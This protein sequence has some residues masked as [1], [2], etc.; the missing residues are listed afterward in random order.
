MFRILLA[1]DEGIMLE[2]LRTIIESNFKG[3]VEIQ[4]VKSGRAAIELAETFRP[5][6]VFMDIQ[7]PGINGIHAMQEIRK[8]HTSV[9]FIVI[10][11]YDKFAYAQEAINLG[12]LEYLTKPVNRKVVIDV[13]VRA[14]QKVEE[15]RRKRSES[16]K[17]QEKLETVI[18]V[19]E[20]GFIYNL[21]LQEERNRETGNYRQLLDIREEYGF[22]MVVQFG[23]A[24]TE[25]VLTNA[26]GMSVKAQS[27]YSQFREIIRGFFYCCI[28]PVMSNK[29]A[30]FVPWE[31]GELTYDERIQIIEKSRNMVRRLEKDID[32]KFKVGIG[33]VK[34]FEELQDSYKEASRALTESKGRVAHVEDLPI[35]CGYVGDYPADTEKKLFQMVLRGDTD[36]ARQQA[37]L[38]FEWMLQNYPDCQADIQIKVLEFV[39]RAEREAFLNGGMTYEFRY[40]KDYLEQVTGCSS[41]EGLRTWFLQKITEVCKNITSKQEEQTEGIVT[42]VKQY[43]K[44]NFQ[45]DISLDGVSEM[46]NISPYYFSKVFKDEAGENFIEYLTKVRMENAKE[47]LKN[48]ELSVKEIC[49]MSGYGDP[50]YFSRIFKK[51]IGVTP[52]EYRERLG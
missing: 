27:F 29:I 43:I 16:L 38:F 31:Q 37:D 19:I 30:L 41:Y 40:R 6:I 28:G 1:D 8:F 51:Y 45:K 13:L 9:H 22:M 33:G 18:P 48:P 25:G 44:S 50:N 26:V 35:G 21:L 15:E 2:S 34:P 3:T 52:S 36:G 11:A 10:S 39:M 5:D 7:M 4:C 20:S 46:V 47:Y 14:M 42:R 12:V 23:E 49:A 24:I 32:A 17:I